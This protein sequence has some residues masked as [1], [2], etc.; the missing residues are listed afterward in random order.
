MCRT[1]LCAKVRESQPL[2]MSLTT[3][4]DSSYNQVLITLKCS[5]PTCTMN[6][7]SVI[8]TTHT[9]LR[10]LPVRDVPPGF[11]VPRQRLA[12]DC[13]I[14]TFVNNLSTSYPLRVKPPSVGF[15]SPC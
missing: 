12:L 6:T 9:F 2:R 11:S 7:S 1:C 8:E 13:K 14:S 15:I 4:R 10:L 5:L 3:G